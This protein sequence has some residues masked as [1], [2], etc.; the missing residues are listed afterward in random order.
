MEKFQSAYDRLG[1]REISFPRLGC[2]NGGLDWN[3]VRPVMERHLSNLSINVYIHDFA[4]DIG[5]P[6]HLEEIA[7]Q[8]RHEQSDDPTFDA[9]MYTLSRAL[10]LSGNR[11]MD[12][13]RMD[14]I[15][16]SLKDGE[17]TVQAV[18]G[19]WQF[20][21]EALRGVWVSLKNGVLTK[22]QAGWSSAE[23]GQR[24][25]SIL[26]VSPQL[27]PIEIQ[28]AKSDEPELALEMRPQGSS[29]LYPQEESK[30]H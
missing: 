19:K 21:L 25:L 9:F 20:D 10:D 13:R 7:E 16:A 30:W 23:G 8:L 5:L 17:L 12:V 18:E 14:P 24:L 15:S 26:S 29:P 28:R 1:I 27:R 11:L 2:G 6:E 4:K 22:E 3:E